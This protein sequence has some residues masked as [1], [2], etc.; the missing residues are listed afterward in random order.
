MKF[1]ISLLAMLA[2]T[3]A[4]A[5]SPE[6]QDEQQNRYLQYAGAPVDSFRMQKLVRW[7]VV[8]RYSVVVWPRVSE[9]YLLTVEPPCF[10]LES[11][12][13]LSLSSK[14]GIV[15]RVSDAVLIRRG[16]CKI[17]EIRPVD[18]KKFEADRKAAK[19]EGKG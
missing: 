18:Y 8:G 15:S 12:D 5:Q 16:K 9:A 1:L 4:F 6:K 2:T 7:E 10:D 17:D 3:F 14:A 11:T 19:G 13:Q